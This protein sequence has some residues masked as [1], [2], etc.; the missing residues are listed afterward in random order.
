MEKVRIQCAKG[1]IIIVFQFLQLCPFFRFRF[2]LRLSSPSISESASQL[3]GTL[4]SLHVYFQSILA[5]IVVVRVRNKMLNT[6]NRKICAN[7]LRVGEFCST[8][9]DFSSF[10]KESSSMALLLSP[11][12]VLGPEDLF[13][14]FLLLRHARGL[15]AI[16][17]PKYGFNF[18]PKSSSWYITGSVLNVATF[19][20]LR[21]KHDL[22]ARGYELGP[23][24]SIGRACPYRAMT[25]IAF[26][27][28]PKKDEV[29]LTGDPFNFSS[30]F[31]NGEM[32]LND[33]ERFILWIFGYD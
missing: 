17:L 28:S 33:M 11:K 1:C 6:I 29:R 10:F 15:C 30:R 3:L 9:K 16:V 32:L 5:I 23:G 7:F 25:A 2:L 26:L 27:S 31:F 19:L 20:L 12:R 8:N 18:F 21:S 4:H 22:F 14:A 13:L 24:T